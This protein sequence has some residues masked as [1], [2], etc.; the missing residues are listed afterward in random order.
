MSDEINPDSQASPA[1][2]PARTSSESTVT[3]VTA[4]AGLQ[5]LRSGNRRRI[6]AIHEHK[7]AG[8]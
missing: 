1:E 7:V 8:C 3:V 5:A 6:I 4:K 2:T